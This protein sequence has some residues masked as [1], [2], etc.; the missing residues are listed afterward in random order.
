MNRG[1]KR[2]FAALFITTVASAG[3]YYF[4]NASNYGEVLQL[5][6]AIIALVMG[7]CVDL[8]FRHSDLDERFSGVEGKIDAALNEAAKERLIA[9]RIT[10]NELHDPI[11]GERFRDLKREI[12]DLSEGVYHIRSLDELYHDDI[13]SIQALKHGEKLFSLCPVC[14]AVSDAVEQFASHTYIASLAAH[15]AAQRDGVMVTRVLSL[16]EFGVIQ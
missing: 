1:W 2:A 5:I 7:V 10:K 16:Q 13:R 8:W 12:A 6:L 14:P 3:I 4:N 11:F 15:D 9:E